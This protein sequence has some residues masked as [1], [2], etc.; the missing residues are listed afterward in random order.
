MR[1]AIFH[2][3]E[4]MQVKLATPFI[5]KEEEEAL[6]AALRSTHISGLSGS[7]VRE[8]EEGFA[9]YCGVRYGI[10]VANGTVALHLAL[11]TLNIGPGDEVLVSTFTNMA[12]FFAVLYTGA[13][14]VP[15][16][17]EPD[18]WNM[19]PSLLEQRITPRTRAILPVH[20]YGHPVD[21]DRVN[22]IAEKYGLVVVEDAAEAHGALYRGRKAGSLSD[23]ACFSFFANKIV[24]TGEGGMLVTNNSELAERARSLKSLAYGRENKFM[25]ADIG[26]NYRMSNL[27]AALGVA[28]LR[29]VE[30]VVRRKRE[31]ASFYR[32][33]LGGI[34]VLQLPTEKNYARNV[35]WMYHVVLRGRAAN[36]RAFVMVYLATHGIETRP[37]FVPANMQKVFIERGF[38]RPDDCPNAN[39]VGENGFY[40]PCSPD[41][42]PQECAHVAY[43][44]KCALK[45]LG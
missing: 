5:G 44:L 8:F 33:E 22:A 28:Q 9:E 43:V 15:I 23:I 38:A 37:A 41:I 6:I 30:E 11:A 27:H 3:E 2:K 19:D 34:P 7:C 40:I 12:T 29:K 35:Y 42:T 10:A 20:I 21:M 36:H 26:F 25:H 13:T 39:Y 31:T 17:I 18:T 45:A 4:D 14:P 32:R 16:D 1:A 24:T